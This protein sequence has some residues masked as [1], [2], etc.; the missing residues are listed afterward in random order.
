MIKALLFTTFICTGEG[1]VQ[2]LQPK[3]TVVESRSRKKQKKGRRRGGNG[4][5]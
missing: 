3:A 4:L 2:A 1:E 5:R